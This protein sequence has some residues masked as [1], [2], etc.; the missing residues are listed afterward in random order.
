MFPA[1]FSKPPVPNV[2]QTNEVFKG[3]NVKIDRL[4]F[5]NAFRDP[6][7]DATISAENHTV[8]STST[9]PI[10]VSDGF[11]CSDLLVENA[12]VDSTIQNVQAQGLKFM[13]NWIP[14]WQAPKRRELEEIER[15][16]EGPT[17]VSSSAKPVNAWFRQAPAL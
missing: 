15:R 1:A 14:E 7:R 11:H 3:W 10:Y 4:F 12:V 6:W 9:Q 2:S 17:L 8:A 5:A 13:A 16:E